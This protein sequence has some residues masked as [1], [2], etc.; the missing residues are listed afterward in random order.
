MSHPGI[1]DFLLSP[2]L[3]TFPSAGCPGTRLSWDRAHGADHSCHLL[4]KGQWAGRKLLGV[5]GGMTGT[6]EM[7]KL[8]AS[9]APEL[10]NL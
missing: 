5:L 7:K 9:P 10:E 8:P 4:V 2:L 1:Q 6:A 3:K